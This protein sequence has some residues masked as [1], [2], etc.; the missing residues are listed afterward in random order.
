MGNWKRVAALT[1][2]ALSILYIIT[3]VVML[4]IAFSLYHNCNE[5]TDFETDRCLDVQCTSDDQC[6]SKTC[7]VVSNSYQTTCYYNEYQ[8][9]LNQMI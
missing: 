4:I 7:S 1:V 6:K 9:A 2:I 5:T 8:K 3:V